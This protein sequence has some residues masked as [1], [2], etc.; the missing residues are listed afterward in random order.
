VL[1]GG[2][3]TPPIRGDACSGHVCSEGCS[4]RADDFLVIRIRRTLLA[5]H[6]RFVATAKVLR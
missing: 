6:P 1:A 4:R 2:R 3:R 5:L